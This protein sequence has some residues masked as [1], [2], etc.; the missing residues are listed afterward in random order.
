MPHRAHTWFTQSCHPQSPR[1]PCSPIGRRRRGAARQSRMSNA[2]RDVGLNNPFS[3]SPSLSLPEPPPFP[4]VPPPFPSAFPTLPPTLPPPSHHTPHVGLLPSRPFPCPCRLPH[5][6]LPLCPVS[7]CA[8]RVSLP[9]SLPSPPTFLL[10]LPCP[11]PCPLPYPL[12]ASPLTMR[13]MWDFS[14]L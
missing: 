6:L 7:P 11:L 1:A 14:G 2:Q 4:P 8:P 3:P 10:L 9:L 12:P 13:P 5:C